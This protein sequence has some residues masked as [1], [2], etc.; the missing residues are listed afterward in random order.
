MHYLMANQRVDVQV[1]SLGE[2]MAG[3]LCRL[4][5]S[6][7]TDVPSFLLFFRL[8]N[9]IYLACMI[10]SIEQIKDFTKRV[11]V[12]FQPMRVLLF[13]SY[14]RG[15]QGEDSDVDLFIIMPFSSEEFF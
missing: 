3:S 15:E 9:G 5:F 6:G 2:F 11:V 10:T 1:N 7:D 13:G 12:Q 14:A 4:S 8:D